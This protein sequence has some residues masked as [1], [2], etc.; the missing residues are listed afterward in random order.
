MQSTLT[1]SLQLLLFIGLTVLWS[2]TW[3]AIKL[4]LN[5][6]V[7]PFMFAGVRFLIASFFMLLIPATRRA[8]WDRALLRDGLFLAVVLFAMPYGLVY[9]GDQ[10]T[11]SYMPALVMAMLPIFTVFF[12]HGRRQDDR[13]TPLRMVG[14]SLGFL[15]VLITLAD[16]LVIQFNWWQMLA[17]AAFLLATLFSAVGTVYAQPR[18]VGKRIFPLLFIEMFAGGLLLMVAGFFAGESLAAFPISPMAIATTLYLAIPG[19]CLGWWA[20]L[21]L[22]QHWGSTKVSTSV[23]FTP[24]L[25]IGFG[26]LLL[27]ETISLGLILGTAVLLLGI[28]LFQKVK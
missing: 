7:P 26:W 20:Y 11:D 3:T 14:L 21:Y 5:E 9:W 6:S 15:G 25:A 13:I 23:F 12:A 1:R 8:V 16:R 10:Y 24:G 2:S 27:D 18:T 4:G 17:I 22:N 28:W 19:S